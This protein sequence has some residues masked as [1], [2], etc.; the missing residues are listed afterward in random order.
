MTRRAPDDRDLLVAP[1]E[2]FGLPVNWRPAR[3]TQTF[4]VHYDAEDRVLEM[5]P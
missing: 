3:G 5:S 2:A 1:L 4:S